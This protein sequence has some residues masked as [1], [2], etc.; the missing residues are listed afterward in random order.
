MQKMKI[1]MKMIIKKKK[2]KKELDRLIKNRKMKIEIK[3]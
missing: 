1:K 2:K 3:I